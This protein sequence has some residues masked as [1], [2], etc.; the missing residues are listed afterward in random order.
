MG[1][2]VAKEAFAIFA[3]FLSLPIITRRN[4]HILQLRIKMKGHVLIA[5]R[6]FEL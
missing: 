4:V 2:E 1:L 3:R 5:M 6:L